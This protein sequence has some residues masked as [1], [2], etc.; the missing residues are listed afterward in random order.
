MNTTKLADVPI[1]EHKAVLANLCGKIPVQEREY[2]GAN[3]AD[4]NKMQRIAL[5]APIGI[6]D[7][8]QAI[9]RRKLVMVGAG[10]PKQLIVAA[11]TDQRV[12]AVA[13]MQHIDAM[14]RRIEITQVA[15]QDI[16]AGTSIERIVP[17]QP[18]QGVC[19]ILPKKLIV[20]V[21]GQI[22]GQNNAMVSFDPVVVIA[23]EQVVTASVA[24]QRV[25]AAFSIEPVSAMERW[26]QG[27]RPVRVD[28]HNIAVQAVIA[29]AS[30]DDVIA[31]L[32]PRVVITT[33]RVDVVVTN[34]RHIVH[35]S[36]HVSVVVD[37]Y[38]FVVVVSNC[39]VF[40][41][42]IGLPVA[43]DEIVATTGIEV[44]IALTA[45]QAI[46]SA[47][48][49]DHVVAGLSGNEIPLLAQQTPEYKVPEAVL[50]RR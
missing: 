1:P 32:S 40:V 8:V 6:N 43:I 20:T 46:E 47:A 23:T 21:V 31:C 50:Y 42:Q 44:V 19:T 28:T 36:C 17:S 18:D 2:H 5:S 11:I 41:W 14:K 10:A 35:K 26:W 25:F 34:A 37:R 33:S 45:K 3:A 49:K 29:L 13:A 9:P 24:D 22:A 30:K 48:T 27:W 38:P 4:T 15:V 7:S 16:V 12:A 39:Q